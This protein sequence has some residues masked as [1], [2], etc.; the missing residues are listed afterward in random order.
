M[1]F[2]R[3]WNWRSGG[4][5]VE[6]G[7]V[8]RSKMVTEQKKW[9]R[10][11]AGLGESGDEQSRQ[12]ECRKLGRREQRCWVGRGH[13]GPSCRGR[14]KG[15]KTPL[16]RPDQSVPAEHNLG[17]FLF[18]LPIGKTCDFPIA[19]KYQLRKWEHSEKYLSLLREL[20]L[21][22]QHTDATALKESTDIKSKAR[23]EN[24]DLKGE[25]QSF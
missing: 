23:A 11:R 22:N 2:L 14:R 20:E 3:N 17:R 9:E 6:P 10:R 7:I 12:T 8:A 19:D 5:Y 1:I 21:T 13:A 18:Q 25:G 16:P 15:L 24:A 4:A